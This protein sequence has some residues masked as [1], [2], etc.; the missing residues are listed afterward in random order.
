MATTAGLSEN[1][2][3]GFEG[4]KA[5]FCLAEIEANSNPASGMRACLRRNG[6]GSRCTGKERDAESGLDYL[7]ARYYSGAQGRFTSVDPYNPMLDSESDDDLKSYLAQPQN[8][9]RYSYAWNNPIRFVDPSGE[10]VEL[11]GSAAD[12]EEA[13]KRLKAMLG[14]S[15][16]RTRTEKGHTYVTYMG[17]DDAAKVLGGF[18]EILS[19]NKTVEFRIATELETKGGKLSTR[20]AGGGLTVGAEESLTGN[21]QIFVHPDAGFIANSMGLATWGRQRSN[22]GQALFFTKDV[23]DAHEFGHA[24]GQFKFGLPIRLSAATNPYAVI[25][26]NRQ[27]ATHPG[28][29]NWRKIH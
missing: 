19:G 26:E 14:T 9:N 24:W 11:T 5:A 21:T 22:D 15:A 23:V 2:H 28:W 16:L 25:W 20:G 1:S 29:K 18:G 12:Q 27:R 4:I 8:W 7:G 17:K 10:L 3:Q 13:L 6:T